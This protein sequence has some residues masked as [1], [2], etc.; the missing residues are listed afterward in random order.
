MEK[1]RGRTPWP[2]R[3][4]VNAYKA[5]IADAIRRTRGQREEFARGALESVLKAHK[6]DTSSRWQAE[7]LRQL[8]EERSAGVGDGPFEKVLSRR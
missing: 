3:K 6:L 7:V 1:T 5:A 4:P 8:D 2:S